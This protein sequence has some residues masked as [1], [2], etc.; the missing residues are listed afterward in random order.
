MLV[1]VQ[2]KFAPVVA[3]APTY[4]VHYVLNILNTKGLVCARRYSCEGEK[5]G[6]KGG[7]YPLFFTLAHWSDSFGSCS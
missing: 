7:N 5:G 3:F 6:G 2:Q 1:S 4:F